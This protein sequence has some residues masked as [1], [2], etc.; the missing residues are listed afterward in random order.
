M[1]HNVQMIGHAWTPL[2]L[3]QEEGNCVNVFVMNTGKYTSDIKRMN[4]TIRK[5]LIQYL[6]H[7]VFIDLFKGIVAMFLILSVKKLIIK[8][9]AY[10]RKGSKEMEQL[11]VYQRDL[12]K[13]KMVFFFN[14]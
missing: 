4:C 2:S 10:A 1:T 12:L 7:N 8:P 14:D 13:K 9:N 11:S 3:K 6:I 5:S